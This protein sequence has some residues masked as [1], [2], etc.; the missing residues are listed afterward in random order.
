MRKGDEKVKEGGK[1]RR[2]GMGR[3]SKR[4]RGKEIRREGGKRGRAGERRV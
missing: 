1:R 4:K 3:E 2:M